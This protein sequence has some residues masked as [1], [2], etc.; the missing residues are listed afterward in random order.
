MSEIELASECAKGNNA[1]RK[2]LYDTYGSGLMAICLRYVASRET[3][4]DVFHDGIIHIFQ[5]IGRFT[6]QGE[7]SLRA[8][9]SRVM[10]NEALGYLRKQTVR[11]QREVVTDE[12]PDMPDNVDDDLNGIPTRVLM[13]FIRQLPEG[14]RTVFNLYVFEEK[15]H[16]EIGRLLGITEHTSSSQFYRARCLLAKKIKEYKEKNI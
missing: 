9:L 14:Y 5:T 4:E 8:W 15:S 16:K 1:A 3:A 12:I 7:G 11:T 2:L 10:A 13:D 6:Y